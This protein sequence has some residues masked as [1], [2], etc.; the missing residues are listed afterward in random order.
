[1]YVIT[2]HGQL[3]CASVADGSII[4][5][6]DLKSEF[7]GKK[8]D[9]WGYSESPL[10]DGRLLLCT[11]GGEKATVVAL[12]KRTGE[13][14]WGCTRPD[15]VGAGH[16]SIV[17]S[18]LD[19]RKVYVQ[20]TGGG[21]M[22]IDPE[23]G[24]MLWSY[25][26]T[27]PTAFIPTPIVDGDLVFSV[28]GYNLGGA[29]LQQVPGADGQVA[30]KEVYGPIK[31]L[32]NKHG[33]VLLIDGKL[34]GANEDKN[35]VFCADLKTGNIDWRERGAGTGSTS[36]ASADGKLVLRFQ[37]GT[38]ALAMVNPAEYNEVCS[39]K[40]PGS[41]GDAMPSWAH[42][43]IANGHLLLREGDAIHCYNISR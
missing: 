35:T 38:V 11:P 15:D 8:K 12:D 18:N 24:N 4:W 32:A 22:G 6:R 43:V 9:N 41:G 27:P 20:N 7:S 10:I 30:I 19:G 13:L 25:D 39:F 36:V 14:V 34:Y 42:P 31:E 3:I 17:I 23:T 29:L 28:A 33:G 16:S 40:T 21:P 37:D 1:M 2:P 5:D 26:M